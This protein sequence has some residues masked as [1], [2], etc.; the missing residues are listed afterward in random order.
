MHSAAHLF[1]PRVQRRNIH[2]LATYTTRL[3]ASHSPWPAY[4]QVGVLL[5]TLASGVGVGS[6]AL[7]AETARSVAKAYAAVGS[8][9]M[10]Q[11][12]P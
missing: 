2:L 12:P 9:S 1:V 8:T 7:L 10:S 5:V 11:G 4:S 6:V 3:A